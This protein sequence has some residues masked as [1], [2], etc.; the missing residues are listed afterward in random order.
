MST[1]KPG[2]VTAVKPWGVWKRRLSNL[3]LRTRTV[4]I[5]K[6]DPSVFQL[7]S[8]LLP[9]VTADLKYNINFV[10]RVLPWNAQ[11][12]QISWA[13][14]NVL[15]TFARVRARTF[16]GPAIQ[17]IVSS[18]SDSPRKHDALRGSNPVLRAHETAL[19]SSLELD[20]PHQLFLTTT[21]NRF[22]FPPPHKKAP[23]S[24]RRPLLKLKPQNG[25]YFFLR[26]KEKLNSRHT[27]YHVVWGKNS[28]KNI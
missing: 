19:L 2:Q 7:L 13:L 9:R 14:R 10:E 26:R 8:P 1:W 23:D 11:P 21:H 22:Y 20:F 24:F 28:L 3:T 6:W 25:E 17:L 27:K 16:L 18:L 12:A 15:F 5:W 4:G